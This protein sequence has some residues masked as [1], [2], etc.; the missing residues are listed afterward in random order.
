MHDGP[1]V[2]TTVFLKGCPLRCRWCHNP[3]TQRFASQVE[4]QR[5]KCV[6]CGACAAAC[7]RGCHLLGEQHRFDSAGCTACFACVEVCP[8]R[9]LNV[10][11][12]RMTVGEVLD[13]VE[14][15]RAFYLAR[16]GMTLSGGEPMAQPAFA[17]ALLEEARR[18]EIGT[19]IETC[20]AFPGQYLPRLAALCDHI[21][22]DV[23]DSDPE[24]HQRNTGG[25]LQPILE[26][27]SALAAL[28]A[29][30]I[31]V[32]CLLLAGVNDTQAH[33]D[34]VCAFA[35]RL[36]IERVELLA[37]HPMGSGKYAALGGTPPADM[38]AARIPT[39]ETMAALRARVSEQTGLPAAASNP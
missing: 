4:F 37:F 35:R 2:R 12:R 30:N 33:V 29:P 39:D 22:F 21:Y 28:A 14:R 32:R 16:G 9:A 19:A 25:A 20:G 11:G 38:T 24:R 17:L 26:N 7:P 36:G 27:L 3:E 15:D 10:C 31:T 13:A 6:G 1:G 5:V 8:V 34:W 23:K 18:R